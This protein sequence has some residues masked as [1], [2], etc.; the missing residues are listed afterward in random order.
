MHVIKLFQLSSLINLVVMLIIPINPSDLLFRFAS[1][2]SS[3]KKASQTFIGYITNHCVEIR[4]TLSH[5]IVLFV[6]VVG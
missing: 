6:A 3:L 4:L 5:I 1:D 2:Y